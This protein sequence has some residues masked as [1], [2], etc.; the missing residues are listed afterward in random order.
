MSKVLK[1]CY[2]FNLQDDNKVILVYGSIKDYCYVN[3]LL[4]KVTINIY[5]DIQNSDE[6]E[7]RTFYFPDIP[8]CFVC[9]IESKLTNQFPKKYC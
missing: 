5:F 1:N 9:L 6:F 8:E 2:E 4:E 3:E 7:E